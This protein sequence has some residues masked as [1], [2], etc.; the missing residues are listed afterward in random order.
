MSYSS[1][2]QRQILALCTKLKISSGRTIV[3]PMSV[4][5]TFIASQEQWKKF[6]D[7]VI[8]SGLKI[9]H[10]EFKKNHRSGEPTMYFYDFSIT[11]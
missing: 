9:E 7:V 3:H 8:E 5:V 11:W 2:L 10:V 1:D 6:Y 4:S